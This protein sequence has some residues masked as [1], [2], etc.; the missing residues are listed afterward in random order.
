MKTFFYDPSD[1]TILYLGS[2]LIIRFV[3]RIIG[4]RLSD[5]GWNA[6]EVKVYPIFRK[7]VQAESFE[8]FLN[9]FGI[10]LILD[11]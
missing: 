6:H 7:F 5:L 3:L 11:C 9:M 10:T 2:N 8:N 1:Y 4:Y